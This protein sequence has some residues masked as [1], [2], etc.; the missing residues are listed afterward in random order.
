MT[1]G[2]PLCLVFYMKLSST[3]NR[4]S[5]LSLSYTHT[6]KKFSAHKTDTLVCE[7]NSYNEKGYGWVVCEIKPK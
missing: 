5:V 4:L 6:Q 3:H 7:Y 1:T 2:A